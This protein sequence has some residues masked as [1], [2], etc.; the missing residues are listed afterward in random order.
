ME[1]T[2]GFLFYMSRLPTCCIENIDKVEKINKLTD[3][4]DTNLFKETYLFMLNGR[5]DWVPANYYQKEIATL[6]QVGLKPSSDAAEETKA[7]A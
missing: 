5:K 7:S 6:K 1:G 4:N 2:E 3:E